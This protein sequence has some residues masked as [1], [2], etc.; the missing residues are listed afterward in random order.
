M[1]EAAKLDK[2]DIAS[3]M[4]IRQKYEKIIEIME[5]KSD[6]AQLIE[7]VSNAQMQCEAIAA[8]KGAGPGLMSSNVSDL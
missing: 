6:D 8:Q 7:D 2:A 1:R 3:E 4:R 5:A